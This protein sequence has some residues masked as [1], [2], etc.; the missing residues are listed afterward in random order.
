[1]SGLFPFSET[2]NQT[3]DS[4]LQLMFTLSDSKL[5]QWTRQIN[6][7]YLAVR[8]DLERRLRSH[9]YLLFSF[10]SGKENYSGTENNHPHYNQNTHCLFPKF[11]QL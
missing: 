4:D 8:G 2:Q 5:K 10:L 1:M 11:F 6:L 3:L 7:L 9:D